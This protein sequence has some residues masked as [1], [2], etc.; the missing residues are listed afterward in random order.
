MALAGPETVTLSMLPSAP[1]STLDT[2]RPCCCPS[3]P[4]TLATSSASKLLAL[5]LLPKPFPP[6][7]ALSWSGRARRRGRREATRALRLAPLRLAE[8]AMALGARRGSRVHK[9]LE[10]DDELHEQ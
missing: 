8:T 2:A 4:S 10:S 3:V 7:L 5:F 1:F 9:R 6:A